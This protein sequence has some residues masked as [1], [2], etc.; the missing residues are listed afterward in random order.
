[1]LVELA[2][3]ENVDTGLD[4][5]ARLASECA[6]RK[7]PESVVTVPMHTGPKHGCM[8][9][10]KLAG[11]SIGETYWTSGRDRQPFGHIRDYT[12]K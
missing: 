3:G 11:W 10:P 1:V 6:K 8:A 12:D 5:G 2:N 9:M 7:R 4:E